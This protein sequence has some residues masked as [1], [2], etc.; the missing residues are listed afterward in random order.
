M[1]DKFENMLIPD[2]YSIQKLDTEEGGLTASIHLNTGHEVYKGHFP[3]QAVVPGVIQLQIV[4]EILEE[5]LNKKLFLQ[6]VSSA[7]YLKIIIPDKSDQLQITIH[8]K[9]TEENAYKV[10]ALIGSNE[11]V[12]TKL[13]A[14][15]SIK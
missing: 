3:G 1:S 8:Y 11:T 10:N 13:K 14:V 4:K 2:F 7:K 6:K 15:L 5:N 9:I 12:F